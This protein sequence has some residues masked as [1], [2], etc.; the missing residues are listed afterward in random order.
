M[1]IPLT[2]RRSEQFELPTRPRRAKEIVR[3][4]AGSSAKP[5]RRDASAKRRAISSANGPLP[6]IRL[7]K[8]GSLSRPP[9]IS[10]SAF[11]TRS[12]LSGWCSCSQA[13]TRPRTS[14]GR[15]RTMKAAVVAPAARAAASTASS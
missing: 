14:C 10:R 4:S 13:S 1:P 5:S 7:P 3:S 6:V 12:R 15:R 9:R 2:A 11:S 8:R